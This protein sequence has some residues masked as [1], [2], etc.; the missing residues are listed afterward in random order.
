MPTPHLPIQHRDR[1]AQG[2]LTRTHAHID[3]QTA[4][5]SKTKLTPGNL[6]ILLKKF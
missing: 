1:P 6:I 5:H 3:L 4:G 2:S